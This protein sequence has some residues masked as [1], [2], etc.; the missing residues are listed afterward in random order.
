MNDLMVIDVSFHMFGTPPEERFRGVRV[1]IMNTVSGKRYFWDFSPLALEEFLDKLVRGSPE[2]NLPEEIERE[3]K[4]DLTVTEVSLHTFGTP[5]E[6]QW[7]GIRVK[8]VRIK[9]RKIYSWNLSASGLGEFLDKIVRGCD[10]DVLPD[11]IQKRL[12]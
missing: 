9:S 11:E 3:G 10:E 4:N 2:V 5:P 8:M 7:R 6:K 1:R 12:F